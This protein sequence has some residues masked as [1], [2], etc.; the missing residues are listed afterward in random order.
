MEAEN[1]DP[2]TQEIP[3]NTPNDGAHYLLQSSIGWPTPA[4]VGWVKPDAEPG[5]PRTAYEHYIKKGD[6]YN[7]TVESYF[8]SYYAIEGDDPD[9][10]YLAF[11]FD[12][13]SGDDLPGNASL[14]DI[15]DE[16]YEAQRC[17]YTAW[18]INPMMD[19]FSQD[20]LLDVSF[21]RS[22][23]LIMR[24]NLELEKAFTVRFLEGV[25]RPGSEEIHDELH[26]LGWNVSA[27]TF[28]ES[29]GAWHYF[30]EASKIWIELFA[31]P[32]QREILIRWAPSRSLVQDGGGAFSHR[33]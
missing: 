16:A 25:R 4:T 11:D 5:D 23:A 18:R 13:D 19:D 22:V 29:H 10:I 21:Y 24:G 20:G 7:Q 9:K 30:N 3:P 15:L 27:D 14:T 12:P 6:T 17:F 33:L 28:S 31:S 8:D 32:I 26:Y 2:A 1:W